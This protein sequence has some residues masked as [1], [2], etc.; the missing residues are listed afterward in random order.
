VSSVLSNYK[1]GDI[2]RMKVGV[3]FVEMKDYV[4]QIEMKKGKL[5]KTVSL[6][7]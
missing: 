5:S 4:N 3:N 6:R 2:L 7:V 1:E